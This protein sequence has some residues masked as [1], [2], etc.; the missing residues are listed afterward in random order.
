MSGMQCCFHEWVAHYR[1]C[2]SGEYVCPEHARLE[3]V[4]VTTRVRTPALSVRTAQAG[5]YPAISALA[6]RYWG[7]TAMECFGRSHDVLTLPAFLAMDD[8][9]V[10]GVLS[11]AVETDRL[12]VVM[13]NV[14]PD[15]QGRWTARS[16]LTAVEG[17]GRARGV[18]RLVIA[19]SNDDLLALYVY[20]RW[21]FVI[22]EI[23]AGAI[24]RH[25][26]REELGFAGIP[27]R[28]EIRL[29]R[30]LASW[31]DATQGRL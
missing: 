11:Y 19:T 29:E 21:G 24:L 10:V 9:R 22:T 15:Y 12:V 27:V 3:V 17:E 6:I 16:L 20:Q 28:D 1:C 14:H 2:R 30:R 7:E 13:L 25:H 4:S 5:D 8:G 18:S 23:R 26:G 31:G